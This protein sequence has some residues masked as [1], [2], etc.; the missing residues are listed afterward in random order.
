MFA[1]DALTSPVSPMPLMCD[2]RRLA[3]AERPLTQPALA[4]TATCFAP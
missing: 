1:V 4:A 2:F 3:R